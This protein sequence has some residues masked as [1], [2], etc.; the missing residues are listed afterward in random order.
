MRRFYLFIVSM[1]ISLNVG[2]QCSVN[3]TTISNASCGLNNGSVTLVFGGNNPPFYVNFNGTP[4]GSSNGAPLTINNLAAG[5]YSFSVT[6]NMGTVCTGAANIIVNSWGSP[7][8]VNFNTINPTC[9][10]CTDGSILAM[11]T[12]G[13]APY[14]FQWNNGAN[15]SNL[16][17]LGAGMYVLTVYDTLGCGSIDTVILSYG[18]VNIYSVSGKAFFDVDNDSVYGVNDIPLA[19][20]QIEKQPSGQVFYTDQNG[21]YVL[22]DSTGATISVTH[23]STTGFSVSDGITSH[24][25]TVGSSNISGLNFALAPDSMFHSISTSTFSFLPRCFTNVGFQTS[26]TNQ[27]TYIDSG[28]VTFNFDPLMAYTSSTPSGTIAGNSI[29]FSFSNLMPFETRTF[30]SFFMLPGN[31]ITL[32]TSTTTATVDGAGNVL[33]TDTSY[34]AFLVRCSYDPNDKEVTPMGVG[35]NH[36][37]YMDEELRYLIR[38]QNT[39]NDTAFNIIVTDT[40]SPKLNIN[41][42]FVIATSHLCW[43]EKIGGELMR[44]HFDDILL[45]D[46]NV[47]EPASHG[48]IYFR[49]KGNQTN[50]DPTVVTNSA[51]IYFDFN[52]PVITNTTLTTFSNSTV[53]IAPISGKEA[54]TIQLSPHPMNESSLLHFDGIKDHTHQLELMDISGRTVVPNITFKGTSYLLQRESLSSGTYFIKITDLLDKNIYYTRLLVN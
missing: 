12:G 42:L 7:L 13:F 50:P 54:G 28:S 38:F 19:H 9:P 36:Q 41:S 20:Q 29:S 44:F 39:G 53:G 16:N 15:T 11:V 48:Y 3:A 25:V 43:I 22:G 37:V 5:N 45:P 30:T 10:T 8:Q 6:D 51:N 47:N 1:F 26:I 32:N 17:G 21:D 4:F 34:V 2:A 52:P 24:A 14:Y 33:S 18:G 40:I 23:L 35:A 27:G 49:I 31:G 46:S